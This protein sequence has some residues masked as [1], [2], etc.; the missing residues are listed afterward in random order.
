MKT[1]AYRGGVITFRIPARW[2]EEYSEFDGGLFYEDRSDLGRTLRLK[3]VTMKSPKELGAGSGAEVLQVIVTK[4]KTDGVKCTIET[5]NDGNAILK[6]EEDTS[7]RGAG[8]TI[9][10][11]VIANSMPPRHARVATFSY[12]IRADER[13]ESTVVR[14]LAML[15]AEIGAATF[16]PVLGVFPA[17]GMTA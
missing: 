10:Y 2:R 7:E 3:I 11:W 15:E 14:D 1:I 13:S 8:L 5:R 16:S 9:F 6:Y 4:L 12:T 17:A